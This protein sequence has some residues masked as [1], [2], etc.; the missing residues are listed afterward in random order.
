MPHRAIHVRSTIHDAQR[1][2]TRRQA[3]FIVETVILLEKSFLVITRR[4]KTGGEK[5]PLIIGVRLRKEEVGAE[6]EDGEAF[7]PLADEDLPF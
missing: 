7:K 1:Q 5:T 3:Q 2:F 4:P 6:E